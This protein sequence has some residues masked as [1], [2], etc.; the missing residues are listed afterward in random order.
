MKQIAETMPGVLYQG[1]SSE[2]LHPLDLNPQQGVAQTHVQDLA[3][4]V[5]DP[6]EV[7]IGQVLKLIQIHLDG[8]LS[9]RCVSD[10]NQLGVICKPV[11]DA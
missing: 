11:E 2:S 10:I 6:R 7:H 5:V 1:L 4:G 9:L 8:I 3:L